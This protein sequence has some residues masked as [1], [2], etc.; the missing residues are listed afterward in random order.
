[1][2]ISLKIPLF[3]NTKLLIVIIVTAITISSLTF[4]LVSSYYEDN[5]TIVIINTELIPLPEKTFVEDQKRY[6]IVQCSDRRDI[7]KSH[8]YCYEKSIV[9]LIQES[10]YRI[11]QLQKLYPSNHPYAS[12]EIL[13]EK[14]SIKNRLEFTKDYPEWIQSPEGPCK[15][16]NGT[17]WIDLPNCSL[18]KI[19]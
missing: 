2:V 8:E 14:Y 16:Y 11:D 3:F 9:L 7:F 13:R 4:L 17:N 12:E 10:L 1:L 6:K 15:Q 18:G 5:P 19:R